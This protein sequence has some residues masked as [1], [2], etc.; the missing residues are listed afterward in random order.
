[1]ITQ[2]S[3]EQLWQAIFD[4]TESHNAPPLSQHK[5]GWVLR[6]D[7]RWCVAINGQSEPL[8]MRIPPFTWTVE[9]PPFHVYVDYLGWP[10]AFIAPQTASIGCGAEANIDTLYAAIVQATE[11]RRLEA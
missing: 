5:S 4:L 10:F 6:L 11:R 3:L 1:M 8:K 9:V 2:T 7:D